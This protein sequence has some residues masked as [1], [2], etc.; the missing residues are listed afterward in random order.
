[1]GKGCKN[2]L[3]LQTKEEDNKKIM[4]RKLGSTKY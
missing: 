4:N 3:Y 2:V 1:M